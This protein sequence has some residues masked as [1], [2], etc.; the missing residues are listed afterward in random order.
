MGKRLYVLSS[1]TLRRHQ[2]TLVLETDEGKRFFPIEQ[3]EEVHVFGEVTLNKRL[4]GF[5]TQQHIPVH[6]YG[7]NGYYIGT[8]YPREHYNSG[9]MILR[10]AEH[11]LDED[12]RLDLARRFVDGALFNMRKVVRYYKNRGKPLEEVELAI[13]RHQERIATAKDISALMQVEGQARDAYYE[14]FDIILDNED[15][16]FEARSRRPPRNRINALISFGNTLLYTAVLSEIYHTHLDPRIGF[17]HATNFR[18][19]TLN[20]DVAEIFKPI[21]VDRLIFTLVGKGQLRARHFDD[22]MGGIYLN[23]SGR[24]IFLEAWENRL[25]TTFRHRGLRRNVSY[26]RALRLELYK[27][28]KHLIGEKPYTPFRARW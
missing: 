3:V 15:F 24:R 1:G 7:H 6:F 28:E 4:L 5:L 12:K 10:Q 23:E 27:L 11:Y 16:A 21:L 9:Y 2:N 25:S 17:L 13:E 22:D 20:L 14:A 18:R 19:F 26:R 8:Y